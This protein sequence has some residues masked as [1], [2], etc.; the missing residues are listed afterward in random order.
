MGALPWA[1][2]T[3]IVVGRLQ[4]DRRF[5]PERHDDLRVRQAWAEDAA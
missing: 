1:V 3:G 2:V 4:H 5:K